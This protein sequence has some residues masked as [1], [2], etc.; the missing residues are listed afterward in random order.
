MITSKTLPS[1]ESYANLGIVDDGIANSM[2][3]ST[4]SISKLLADID[5]KDKNK[6]QTLNLSGNNITLRGSSQILDYVLRELPNV[7]I[8]N[9]SSNQIRDWHGVA[10]YDT[11]E[12]N[13]IALLEIPQFE[14]IRLGNNPIANSVWFQDVTGK[15][16]EEM[17]QKIKW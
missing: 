14:S 12:T 2:G 7:K 9:L 5:Q 11:F 6:I 1:V 13:L 16:S 17:A 4:P 8:L 15:I 10:G 3:Y